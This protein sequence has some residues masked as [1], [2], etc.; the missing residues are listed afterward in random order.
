MILTPSN[1]ARNALSRVNSN[2][3]SKDESPTPV[4][5]ASSVRHI[6]FQRIANG[7]AS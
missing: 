2:A 4:T 1:N 7:G 3:T 6:R 5:L